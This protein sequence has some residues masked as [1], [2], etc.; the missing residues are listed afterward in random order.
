MEKKQLLVGDVSG[1][2]D[3]EVRSH[4]IKEFSIDE[5]QLEPY[6]VV[7]ASQNEDTYDGS[8]YILLKYKEYGEFYEVHGSHCSCY[9]YEGQFEPEL[10]PAEYLLSQHN[11]YCRNTE[12][13]EAFLREILG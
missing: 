4:I 13:V 8:F 3:A 11:R 2:T 9:Y 5:S 6:E 12:S 10:A 7:M 1:M